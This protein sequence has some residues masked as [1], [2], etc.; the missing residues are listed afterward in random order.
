MVCLHWGGKEEGVEESKVKLAE[1]RLIL[2]QIYFTLPQFK[3]TINL[4]S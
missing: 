2:G 1:N 3:W 4:L